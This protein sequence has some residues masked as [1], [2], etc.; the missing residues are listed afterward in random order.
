[1]QCL[2]NL[3]FDLYFK[4]DSDKAREDEIEKEIEEVI[5][6]ENNEIITAYP[7]HTRR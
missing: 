1:M 4:H 3:L 6:I 5:A 7:I 2:K